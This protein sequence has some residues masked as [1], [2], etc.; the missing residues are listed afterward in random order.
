MILKILLKSMSYL[1]KYS[2]KDTVELIS[3]IY[4]LPKQKFI[5]YV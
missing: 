3:T 1:Q 4:N 5:K 2:L